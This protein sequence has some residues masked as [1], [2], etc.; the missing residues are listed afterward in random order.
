MAQCKVCGKELQRGLAMHEKA[1][2]SK[3][4][5]AVMDGPV[6]GQPRSERGRRR[7]EG[8]VVEPID[9]IRMQ[10]A[11]LKG[12]WCYALR[13]EGATI[14][15]ALILVP[16]GG[17]PD[18]DP[19]GRFGTNSAYFRERMQA[20]GH[21]YVGQKLTMQAVR[22]LVDILA[23][24][25]QDEILFVE[26]E[27]ANEQHTIENSDNPRDREIARRRKS[28]YQKRLEMLN[29]PFD[30]DALVAELD[31]IARAQRLSQID[32]AILSVMKEY[33]GEQ[34]EKIAMLAGRLNRRTAGPDPDML[35]R[36]TRSQKMNVSSAQAINDF[37]DSKDFIDAD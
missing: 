24:N 10:P 27:I 26:D 7:Y 30:P 14:P 5:V 18:D 3:G 13:P 11:G 16:N 9:Q 34:N 2:A 8:R 23:R 15:D 29:Q 21:I 19:K 12:A 22:Q 6:P 37:S 1:C 20:K 25:R 35:S 33:V 31:E 28:Q 32:P 4:G 17:A 36:P